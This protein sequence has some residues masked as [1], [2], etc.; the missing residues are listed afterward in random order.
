MTK[1]GRCYPIMGV[2][3]YDDYELTEPCSIESL[4]LGCGEVA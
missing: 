1:K 3:V 4:V 2:A